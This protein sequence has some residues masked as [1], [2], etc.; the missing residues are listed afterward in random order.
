MPFFPFS[1]CFIVRAWLLSLRV[2]LL[3]PLHLVK[4]VL[5]Q[6][7]MRVWSLG[8]DET[9]T[10]PV[11]TMLLETLVHAFLPLACQD[12]LFSHG[13]AP[14]FC[15]RF[16]PVYSSVNTLCQGWRTYGTDVQNGRREDFLGTRHSLLSHFFFYF[17][18]LTSVSIL[19]RIFVHIYISNCGKLYTNYRCYQIALRIKQFYT[20]REQCEVLTGYLSLGCR[21]GGDWANIWHW[22]ERFIVFFSNT[23]C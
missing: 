9:L 17:F 20:N 16:F 6:K 7:F 13:N 12:I 8:H 10:R 22:T 11:I 21:P 4:Q 23:K 2:S 18:C 3:H 1:C 15:S 14:S 5:A 19:W